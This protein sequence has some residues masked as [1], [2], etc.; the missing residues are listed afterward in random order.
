MVLLKYVPCYAPARAAELARMVDN[1]LRS[2]LVI[3]F[4]FLNLSN[5]SQSHSMDIKIIKKQPISQSGIGL[6]AIIRDEMYF[7]PR[8]FEYYRK[9]GVNDFVIYDDRSADGS[10][11]FLVS[12]PDC[13]VLSGPYTYDTSFG[14]T[15]FGLPKKLFD[16]TKEVL[17]EQFFGQQWV[18]TVDADEFVLLP[19]QFAS[20]SD[21]ISFLEKG[22]RLF[23]TGPMADFYPERLSAI[24]T[25]ASDF[26]AL[27]PYFDCGPLYE[28]IP[29]FPYVRKLPIGIR[30]RLGRMLVAKCPQLFPGEAPPVSQLFKVPLLKHG[31]GVK[32]IGSHYV[33][34]PPPA[35]DLVALAHFKFY[36]GVFQKIATAISEKQHW[37]ESIEYRWLHAI[38]EN[39][40]NESLLC[41][42]SRK[43]EGSAS[44][45]AASLIGSP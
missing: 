24:R 38:M 8:F 7:L 42:A 20:L 40:A 12:Q 41:P 35:E 1:L 15:P 29:Q 39:L 3:S 30:G 43:F 6:F 26:F 28:R 27:T 31:Q 33:N 44:L 9:L 10:T 4:L 18:V 45:E 11:E 19:S 2:K 22:A 25:E 13:T 17:P 32:R 36:P 21:F 37:G 14:V 34:A 23:A 5:S 16:H